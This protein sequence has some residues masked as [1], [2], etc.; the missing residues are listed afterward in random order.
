MEWP[1]NPTDPNLLR[2]RLCKKSDIDGL[3]FHDLRHEAVSRLF[4]MNL[5]VPEVAFI[6]GH[7]TPS[8]LF[9]YAQINTLRIKQFTR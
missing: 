6:S 7:K 2:N 9:K 1:N 3:R 8:Q 5:T 4:E